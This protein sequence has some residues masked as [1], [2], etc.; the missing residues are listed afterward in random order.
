MV[1]KMIIYP[2]NYNSERT[3]VYLDIN[4]GGVSVGRMSFELFDDITPRAALNFRYLCTGD[5]KGKGKSDANLHFKGC[6]FHRIVPG[7][8]AQSG[9]ITRGDGRGGC[10]IWGEDF[11]DENFEVKHF[12]AGLLSMSNRGPD[13]NNSQ[14]F[15]TLANTFW[16]DNKHVVFGQMIEG[17]TILEKIEAVGS[18]DGTPQK[19][20]YIESCGLLS[21]SKSKNEEKDNY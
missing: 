11:A 20:V 17:K 19:K 18:E 6:K 12:K 7:K 4:I 8:L 3:Y 14:F 2:D 13:T 5:K 9:D 16:Y 10:S 1:S 21:Y 15:I